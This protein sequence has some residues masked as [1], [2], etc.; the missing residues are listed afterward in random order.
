MMS[1]KG[2]EIMVKYLGEQDTY[3]EDDIDRVVISWRKSE[4]ADK[5]NSDE[6][7]GSLGAYLGELLIAKHDLVWCVYKDAR[8]SDLCITH[9]KIAVQTFPHSTVYKAAIEGR[10]YAINDV[11]KALLEQINEHI[12]NIEIKTH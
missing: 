5:E 8:G 3:I 10:E 2:R 9:K 4:K 6:I 12:D 11:S 7:I 1:Q